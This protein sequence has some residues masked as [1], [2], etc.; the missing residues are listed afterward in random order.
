MKF[1]AV[2]LAVSTLL[3]GCQAAKDAL[4]G[5]EP[6]VDGSLVG[7]PWAVEDL[8]GGGIFASAGLELTFDAEPLPEKPEFKPPIPRSGQISGRS[9]CNRLT[10]SWFQQ[11]GTVR[12]GPLAGTRM[13]CPPAIVQLETK[14]LSTLG[15]VSAVRFDASGAAFLATPDG[16]QLRLRRAEK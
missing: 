11:G 5:R 12:I 13:A 6:P 10:G 3:A 1:S 2:L 16:R 14:F 7:G 8:N 4:N 9:G 15:A